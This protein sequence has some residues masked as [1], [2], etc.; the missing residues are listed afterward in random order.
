MFQIFQDFL[1]DHDHK[2][3]EADASIAEGSHLLVNSVYLCYYQIIIV[4]KWHFIPAVLQ[5]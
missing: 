2:L 1:L 4:A 3:T 5:I